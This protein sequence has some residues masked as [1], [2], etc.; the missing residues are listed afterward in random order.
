[1]HNWWVLKIIWPGDE[2]NRPVRNSAE[3]F[4]K[5]EADLRAEPWNPPDEKEFRNEM[6]WR[7]RLW[8]GKNVPTGG[9]SEQFL[10][11]LARASGLAWA[12]VGRSGR[13]AH[14]QASAAVN[15]NGSEPQAD[16]HADL[17]EH[18]HKHYEGQRTPHELAD[19]VAQPREV[20]KRRD[21]CEQDDH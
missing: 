1:M 5:L 3:N 2:P 13:P 21:A 16:E 4:G 18:K 6:T 17:T 12:R 8:S 14:S 15:R 11:A 19:G 9:T 7:A 20:Q 10:T